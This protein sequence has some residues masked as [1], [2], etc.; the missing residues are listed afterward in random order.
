MSTPQEAIK[1]NLKPNQ[2]LLRGRVNTIRKAEEFYF[3]EVTL[4][5]PDEYSQPAVVEIRSRKRIGQAGD[6]VE[7]LIGCGGYRGKSFVYT[8]KETGERF[9]RRPVVNSYVAIED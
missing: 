3:T 1:L 8:D 6:T 5:A 9:N 2:S 7:C 4:P